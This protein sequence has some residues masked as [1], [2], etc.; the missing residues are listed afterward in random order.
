MRKQRVS[1]FGAI[2]EFSGFSKIQYQAFQLLVGIN[3]DWSMAIS[4]LMESEQWGK[5]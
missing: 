2:D 1:N 4:K 3:V 5:V